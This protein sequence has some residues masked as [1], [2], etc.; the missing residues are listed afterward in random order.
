MSIVIEALE[1]KRERVQEELRNIKAEIQTHDRSAGEI[2]ARYAVLMGVMESV[3]D[4]VNKSEKLPKMWWTSSSTRS[5]DDI[6][7]PL[8]NAFNVI[9]KELQE[10]EKE[11]GELPRRLVSKTER[12]KELEEDIS[13]INREIEKQKKRS[14]FL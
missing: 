3:K 7:K 14:S 1:E 12:V 11:I 13:D 9:Y 5:I 10:T 6:K 8:Q 4:S 2:K